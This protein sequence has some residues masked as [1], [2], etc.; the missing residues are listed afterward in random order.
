MTIEATRPAT[1]RLQSG[2]PYYEVL[3][4][5]R[6]LPQRRQRDLLEALTLD[7]NAT[8][9]YQAVLTRHPSESGSD[10][11]CVTRIEVFTAPKNNPEDRTSTGTSTQIH[12]SAPLP[13]ETV[14]F[15]HGR[16]ASTPSGLPRLVETAAIDQIR[17]AR[18]NAVQR[19]AVKT[20]HSDEQERLAT[21]LILGLDRDAQEAAFNVLRGSLDL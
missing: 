4:E 7:L 14:V 2:N 5:V 3:H 1:T 16:A 11:P 15:R 9:E 6:E 13:E 10:D 20:L 21:N 8:T 12:L 18:T 19:L 17:R